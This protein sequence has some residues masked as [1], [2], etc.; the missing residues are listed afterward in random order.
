MTSRGGSSSNNGV[1]AQSIPG[2]ARKMVQ[3]LKEIVNCPETEIYAMLKDCNMDPNETVNRLISQDPFHEVKSKRDKKKEN[4]D[5]TE[6][7]PRGISNT[8]SRGG[9]GDR[10]AGRGGSTSFNSSEFG[11]LQGK[12]A[13]KKDNGT[14]NYTSPSFVA[15]GMARN[16][17]NRQ[18]PGH[19][20]PVTTEYRTTEIGTCDGIL[21]SSQTSSGYQPAWL[22]VPD[23]VSMADIVKMGRPHGKASS[24]TKP[25]QYGATNHH[26]QESNTAY[27]D[28]LSSGNYVFKGSKLSTEPGAGSGQHGTSN[29]EWPL[30]EQPPATSV[31]PVL[32]PP[33]AS[34]LHSVTSYL[35][36]SEIDHHPES[37]R[38][39][40]QVVEDAAIENII[41]NQVGPASISS[42]KIQEDNSGGSSMFN[43]DR[44]QNMASCQPHTN[45]FECQEV[46]HSVSVS[47]ITSNL[48]QLSVQEDQGAAPEEDN[49][50]VIIPSHLQVQSAD[51]SHL[52]FGSFR[53]GISSFS[54]P[55]SAGRSQSNI[56]E[57]SADADAPSV[58]HLDTRN[59]E[60]Y[61]DDTHR[62]ASDGNFHRI[63][64]GA[65]SYDSPSASQSEMLNQENNET[66]QE[67]QYAF[68]SSSSNYNFENG[69]HMDD[70]FPHSHASPQMQNLAPFSSVMAHTNS[71]PSA[72][73]S[74]SVQPVR[75]S[76][77]PY[78]PFP[79]TQSMPS[80]YGNTVSSIGGSTLSVPEALKA[81]GFSSTQQTAQ[82]LPGSNIATGPALPQHLAVHPY[83]QPTL[84]LGPFANM[85]GYP[86]LPQ[87]YTYMPSAFQ[88]AFAGNSTYHQSLAGVVPQY[89][90]SVPVS[91]LAQSTAI[92][93]GYGGFG[94][95]TNFPMNT[96][97]APGP[98]TIGYDDVISSQ[99]KDT[100]HLISLQQNENSAVWVHGPG[101]RTM[102]AVPASTYYSFQG[103]SQ[104]P[105][106]FRQS[107]QQPSQNYGALGYPNFYHSQSGISLEQLQQQNPRDGPSVALKANNLQGS[108]NRYGKTATNLI[109][110]QF[111]RV[112]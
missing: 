70:S 34:E 85:I 58:V 18:P 101:S 69:R 52:S 105:S 15:A 50:S 110:P 27:H 8:S 32:D 77:L 20:D 51:C 55:F 86:F 11:G 25:S 26:F 96:P 78:S 67:D 106:G 45:A 56:D 62:T 84:P 24:M 7:R 43:S 108:P 31:P 22:G 3:S 10:Y 88:Q 90:N 79:M 74:A 68:P 76:D 75:E 61:G 42:T 100:S 44:Y 73:L 16:N 81:A 38:D 9:R 80:K 98:T 82:T 97:A 46:E 109:P 95:S 87:S 57:V 40:F 13:Y 4:K 21:S 72:L 30:M 36:S 99:Y 39:E 104:Q 29:D 5:T 12:P 53:C 102:S 33:V 49:P 65:G 66:S 54:G 111:F 17:M 60:Y 6:S 47:T 91:S 14:N 94:S 71:L 93:S 41:A 83:S 28:S 48:E 23:Q 92:T 1:G 112:L 19:S 63:G 59:P 89:K 35:S 37:E 103:Q 107:Q 64:A 2:A